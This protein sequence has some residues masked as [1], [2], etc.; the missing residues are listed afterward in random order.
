MPTLTELRSRYPKS[1]FPTDRPLSGE[2]M[3]V[4]DSRCQ[5]TPKQAVEQK[6]GAALRRAELRRAPAAPGADRE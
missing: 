5:M 2:E 6:L 3:L 4:S 1:T